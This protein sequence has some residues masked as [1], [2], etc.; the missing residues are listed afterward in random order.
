[1]L[2]QKAI[3]R[4]KAVCRELI[5][6]IVFYLA[7]GFST[8]A[9]AQDFGSGR[10][11]LVRLIEAKAV[12]LTEIAG[13]PFRIVKG[14]ARFMHNNTYLLCDSAAWDVNSNVIDAMGHV[15]IIQQDTYLVSE[16]ATYLADENLAQFRGVEVKLY[17][18]KGDQLKTRF[19]DYNTAD[20]IATFFNGGAMR[21]KKGDVIE[22]L[23][24]MYDSSERIFMFNEDVC[25]YSDS[26]FV[27]SYSAEYRSD[28]E[29]A[30]FGERTVAWRGRDTLFSNSVE[31]SVPRK[32]LVLKADNYIATQNQEL[33]AGWVDYF[34]ESGNAVLSEDVQVRDQS[35]SAIIMGDKGSYF[36]DPMVVYMTDKASAA[37]Y[38]EE[39]TGVDTL[40]GRPIYK[41]DT[42]FIAGD[43]LK[44]WQL[45]KHQIDSMEIVQAL[46]RRKLA[47]VDPLVDIDAQNRRF[48]EAYKRNKEQ[49]GKVI[50][51]KPKKTKDT[52]QPLSGSADTLGLAR[53]AGA[54]AD[55]VSV[56]RSDTLNL[57]RS[58]GALADS[59]SVSRSDTLNLA[60][61]AGALADSVSISRSDTLNLARSA[62]ALADSVSISRSDT[63][64]L[65]RSAEALAVDSVAV[66]ALDTTKITFINVYNKVKIFRSDLRG[67]CDSLIYTTIDSIARFYT[68]PVL[69]N[70][71]KNQFTADSIQLSIRNNEIY[72]ANLIE[73]AFIVSQEDSVHFH[74]IK[75]TEMVAYFRNND[76][77]RFDALGGVQAMIF[78]RERDSSVTLMNQKECK[79][80]TARIVNQNIER[81]RYIENVKSDI[82]PTYKLPID[83]QRLRDFK[84][85][86]DEMPKSRMEL[87]D[88]KVRSSQR[89]SLR[90]HPFPQ[91][92]F[93]RLF[94]PETYDTITKLSQSITIRIQEED[95]EREEQARQGGRIAGSDAEVQKEAEVEEA[96]PQQRQ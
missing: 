56:S 87:T 62:G 36:S 4:M 78:L 9:V 84:W 48:L 12:Q 25:M 95:F 45:P 71:D 18:K 83:K 76:V 61:S 67:A 58:A 35:Q 66:A 10:D 20:S 52:L 13:A 47:D 22:G 16:F 65:S 7:F 24:G 31:Y 30:F 59:V 34:R 92:Q 73:N 55:S 33:W 42:L 38:S 54:L 41:R 70:E 6:C 46:E 44:M 79:L 93:T 81:V 37:M 72:K 91:Y 51:P 94:F 50:P 86:G 88:R 90:Q 17:N 43:T 1:M 39:K 23:E 3:R 29:V 19:L 32:L 27:R 77:Y 49:I 14:P 21:S 28:I 40:S 26:I 63:L 74:Q 64:N 8:S 69:W 80:L 11:S 96:Q 57:A 5:L 53:S 82:I 60:R 15:Q 2:E 75:S 89:K 85:R 68:N